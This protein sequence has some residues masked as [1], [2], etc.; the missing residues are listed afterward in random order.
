MKWMNKTFV[1]IALVLLSL[2]VYGQNLSVL[3]G[4]TDESSAQFSVLVPKGSHYSVNVDGLAPDAVVQVDNENSE[5]SV[6]KFQYQNLKLGQV[7]DLNILNSDGALIDQRQFSALDTQK[8]YQKIVMASCMVD[9]L[10]N[11]RNWQQ[12][13]SLAPDLILF[14]G[15][16][17]YVDVGSPEKLIF[18]PNPEY[19]DHWERYVQTRLRLDIYRWKKLVPVLAGMDDHDF[20]YNNADS[21]FMLKSNANRAFETFFAQV[22]ESHTLQRGPGQSYRFDMGDISYVFL[23]GRNFRDSV[24]IF[25]EEQMAWL[26]GLNLKERTLLMTGSQFFGA[27]LKKDSF[28]GN[29]GSAFQVFLKEL[30]SINTRF[31][32]GSG[33]IHFS[34]LMEI[35]KEALGY[36]TFEITSSSMHS[37]TVPGRHL[38]GRY[39]PR[40]IPGRVTSTHNFITIDTDRNN[41]NAWVVRSH[42]WRGQ[43]L[44]ES[45]L[46][47]NSNCSRLLTGN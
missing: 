34:E 47:F 5:W 20:G 24:Q 44:F 13:Q 8:R 43:N 6:L 15:D 16:A 28:E 30:R 40:R 25:S 33:D 27:Y 22:G 37:F 46:S 14:T 36:K 9:W 2:N 35:E 17:V 1:E 4:A 7:Y 26:H 38:I 41:R 32:F 31:V 29:Y 12:M 23:D 3:Q 21:S 11:P 45:Q 19:L 39:N 18:R 10:H 42:G